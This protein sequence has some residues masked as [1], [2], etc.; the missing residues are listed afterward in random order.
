MVNE[1]L[2]REVDIFNGL[3]DAQLEKVGAI[4][5]EARFMDGDV[6]LQESDQSKEMYVI[7]EGE[8]EI[9][10]GVDASAYPFP[11]SDGQVLI[12]RLG[13]GQIF[14]EMALVDQGLRSATVRCSATPTR[15]LIVQRD[16]FM[17]LCQADT[18]LGFVVMRN[19]AADVCFKLRS[20]N[21]AW[22]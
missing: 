3:S 5:H 2:L 18:H 1:S 16:D 9:V 7:A 15:L 22:K 19:V 21:L 13:K 10:L 6:I 11:T 8:V 17:A 14:G 4:C 12:V 20:H